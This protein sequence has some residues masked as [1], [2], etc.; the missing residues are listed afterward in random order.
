[1]KN[2]I[3]A[4]LLIVSLFMVSGCA[5]RDSTLPPA[6]ESAVEAEDQESESLIYITQGA[7]TNDE[8][9]PVSYTLDPEKKTIVVDHVEWIETETDMGLVAEQT[10]NVHTTDLL[11][12]SQSDS[13]IAFSY[14]DEDDRE[15]EKQFE[16]LSD[17]I[18]KDENEKRYEWHY[19]MQ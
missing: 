4:Y 1:M 8:E 16:I 13:L 7:Q 11:T 5:K 19:L 6:E 3:Y 15:I 18:V 17:S 12:F 10:F 9:I 14:L 2:K